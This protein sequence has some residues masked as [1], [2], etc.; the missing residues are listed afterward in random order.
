MIEDGIRGGITHAILRYAEANNRYMDHYDE[1]K[2]SSYLGYLDANN[3]YG[4]ATSKNC[5]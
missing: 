4:W 2:E 3:L 1:S 5:S